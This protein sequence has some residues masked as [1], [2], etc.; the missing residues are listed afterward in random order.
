M[1]YVGFM[2]TIF[3]AWLKDDNP[4]YNIRRFASISSTIEVIKTLHFQ[5]ACH[6]YLAVEQDGKFRLA[7]S[8]AEEPMSAIL[9]TINQRN[10]FI[11]KYCAVVSAMNADRPECIECKWEPHCKGGCTY[12]RYFHTGSFDGA[13]YFCEAYKA[14]FAHVEEMV[15]PIAESLPVEK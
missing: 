2:S 14:M 3:D 4:E 11:R 15:K 10:S 1:E 9:R 7:G 5:H 13:N 8:Q 6:R 12:Y